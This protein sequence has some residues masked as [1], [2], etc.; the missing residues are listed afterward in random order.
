MPNQL[1]AI[2]GIKYTLLYTCIC[3]ILSGSVHKG[4]QKRMPQISLYIDE[5]TLRKV[6]ILAKN[7]RKSISK[8]V[9]IKIK[10]V[11]DTSWPDNYFALFG[12]IP[13]KKFDRPKVPDY[14]T[15]VIRE[16]I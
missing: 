1:L 5:A 11:L 6:E 13:D 12:S 3:I 7:E 15:D 4:K 16:Q 8:W 9:R 2:T 14:K 10:N